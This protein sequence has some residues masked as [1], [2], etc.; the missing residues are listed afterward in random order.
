M[1][2]TQR[3]EQHMFSLIVAVKKLISQS[4]KRNSG[5]KVLE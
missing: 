5:Y 1:S 3:D 4:E 2:Q